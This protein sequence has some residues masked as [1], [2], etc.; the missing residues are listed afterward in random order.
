MPLTIIIVVGWIWFD[1]R[2]E[3]Q[4]AIEDA[5]LEENIVN[6]E[7][8]IMAMMRKRTMSKANTWT[9]VT[10]PIRP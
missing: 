5:D 10:S 6:M 8:E 3:G 4:F 9:S 1:R 7:A 2:R